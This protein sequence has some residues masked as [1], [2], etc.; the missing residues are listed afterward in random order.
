M[1][2]EHE[3]ATPSAWR[4]FFNRGGW[5]KALGVAVVYLALYQGFGLLSGT[6]FNDLINREN[7]F[8]DAASVFF[9]LA[10]P[11]LLGGIVLLIFVWSLG[12]LGEIF[13]RQPIAGKG[14]MWIAVAL[15]VIPIGLRLAGTDWSSYSAGVVVTMLVAG[16][17]IGFAEEV[18]TRGIGVNLL[19][20]AGYGEKSVMLLSSLLF[21]LLHSVNLL[22]GQPLLNV[23][24]TVV[25]TFGF[26]VMMYLVLRVTGSIIWPILLHA[27]TDP[28]TFLATGGID[29]HTDS[30]GSEAL[31]SVAGLFNIIYLVFAIVAIILVKGKVYEN[32]TPRLR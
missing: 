26:G 15:L 27:A 4:R 28:T 24:V 12:W 32:R 22:S 21:A 5:W 31:L 16:L 20:R 10:L 13:G 3:D 9:G 17:F 18:L 19:R 7:I 25:Y 23:G 1:V 8:A 29:A 14:W 6:L 11:I 30:A 2:N